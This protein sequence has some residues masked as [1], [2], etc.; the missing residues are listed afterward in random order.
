MG[1]NAHLLYAA[2]KF[3]FFEDKLKAYVAYGVTFFNGTAYYGGVNATNLTQGELNIMA[4]FSI[5]NTLSVLAHISD[6][7]GGR[8]V[9]NNFELNGGVRFMF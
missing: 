2:G 1:R 6:T 5:T 9:P 3:S 7:H 4:E 8:T